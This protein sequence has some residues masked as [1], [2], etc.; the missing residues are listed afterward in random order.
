MIQRN[1][2]RY[3]LL[4]NGF[5]K[6]D[7]KVGIEVLKS[8]QITMSKITEKYEKE[9]ARK[10][11]VKYAVMVNSGSSANLLA[12]FASS[13]PLRKNKFRNGDEFLIPAICWSTSLWPFVQAG[14][15]PVFVDADTDT[16]NISIEDLKKKIT[17]KTKV[18][19]I[20][21]VLGIS[22]NM[23]EIKKICKKKKI[24]L[25][26]DTC[27]SLG[28]NFKGKFLGTFGDF[29]TYSFYYSH[30]ITSGEGGMIVCHSD[31]D[32]DILLSLRSHGWARNLIKQ[33]K[34]ERKF[35]NLDNRFIFLNSG[36]NLRPTEIQAA[37]SYNQFK[38]LNIL[39]NIK[40]YNHNRII[41][42]LEK[43]KNWSNQFTF[44]KN[45]R[46]IS[47]NWFG[48]SILINKPFIKKKKEFIKFLTKVGIENRP[49]I[50]GNFVNQ[51][52][53]KLYKFKAKKNTLLKSQEIEDRGFFIGLGNK[54]INTKT[55]D[56]LSK[57]LLKISQI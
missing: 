30:Q 26:E 37:I 20:V 38:R 14:M 7:I 35:K 27:E 15:K 11:G 12:A 1:K 32:Y 42:S 28:S 50:S 31:E 51:P 3:P 24:I 22:S 10:V 34:Y 6:Q 53:F 56:F 43:H 23:S 48:L 36:F 52:S 55:L 21:H 45:S 41:K 54:K 39:K 46:K 9:F 57:N 4:Q 49:I 18:L 25:I 13:N 44:I 16:L 8:G 29:G 17:N 33:K 5:S 2:F 47:P 19:V 40:S